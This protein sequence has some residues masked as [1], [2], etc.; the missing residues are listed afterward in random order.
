MHI[1]IFVEEQSAEE[2]LNHLMLLLLDSRHTFEIIRFPGKRALLKRLPAR[3]RGYGRWTEQSLTGMRFLVLVD[4][5]K[6][7]CRDLKAKLELMAQDAGF[8][9]T[10][11]STS[12]GATQVLI[13]I[14]IEELEAWYFGDVEALAAAYP[15]LG[16]AISRKSRYR[17][18]DAISGGTWEALE[19]ELQRKGYHKG[20]LEKIRA[21]REI[22][23][24]IDPARNRSQSFQNF[25]RGVRRLTS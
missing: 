9:T 23:S 12:G 3:L 18:P 22:G 6:D 10:T 25:C 14:A 4:R 13:R 2:F 20:G 1:V 19:R 16:T 8:R 5:D 15:R 21:A 17:D 24:W 7:D 11:S